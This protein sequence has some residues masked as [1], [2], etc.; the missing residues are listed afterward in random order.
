MLVFLLVV[1]WFILRGDLILPCV[2]LFLCFKVLLAL[3]LPRSAEERANL[4]VFGHV[5]DL[6]LF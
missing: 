2:R 4:S 5:F 3:R 1:L 6:R